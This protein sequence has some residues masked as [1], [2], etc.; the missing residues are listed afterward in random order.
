MCGISGIISDSPRDLK[1]LL[2]TMNASI[3]H[4]GPDANGVISSDQIGLGHVRLSIIDLSTHANQPFVDDEDN[5]ALVFN[6]EIYNFEEL[7]EKYNFSC[8]TSSDTE[9]LFKGLK[10]VGKD[11][12][13]ELNG[14][15]SLAFWNKENDEVLIARDR[16]GIKPIYVYNKDGVIAFCSELKGLQSIENELNGFSISMD[17]V[18]AFMYLGFIPAPLTIYNEI[19]KFEQGAI[20]VIKQGKISYQK[21]WDL[22]DCITEKTHNDERKAKSDLKE[23]VNSSI[24]YRLKSDVPFGTFLSGGIDS[25]LVTAVAQDL[26]EE[27]VK[28]FSI[29]F[30]NPKFNEA[31]F[32]KEVA[33]YLKTDHHEFLVS[34]NEAKVLVEDLIAHYDEP[35]G[36]PSSIPTMM[37]SEMARKHVKMVLSGDGGDEVFHGYGFYNWANR[38]SNPMIKTFR[39]PIGK[40]LSKGNNRVKRASNVF[41]Y[42][43]GKMKSHIFS[44]E[45]YF[46][47]QKE[48]REFLKAPN[49][50][51]EFLDEPIT[52]K[53]ELSPKE[54]QSLYDIKYFLRDDLLN[55]VDIASMKYSLEVRVPLLD[56][57]LIEFG[58]NVHEDLKIKGQDS[59]YI[60]KQVL[61]DYIP[62]KF[63]DR[64]KKGF[65][66]PLQSWLDTDLSYLIDDNLNK[67]TVE[68]IG[69]VHFE[70]VEELLRRYRG[71]E[72]YLF[73]RIWALII[74]HEW[75]KRN[76]NE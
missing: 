75:I 10:T 57:R 70:K 14:M 5:Y 66:I 63:F 46:F 76:K 39:T 9:V 43:K 62:K 47:S 67:S 74:L 71:G 19:Q 24:K 42:P 25:S 27:P 73:T 20:A 13:K 4:R 35:F 2:S 56:H 37:V 61:Y 15:F 64:P 21:F 28:T 45:Q 59:K 72:G 34:E 29:G 6:G 8:K 58:V 33:D 11:F 65:N 38:L 54:E 52:G 7:R 32:A 18:N 30:D 23:L 26:T 50:E 41:L 60:L 17:A 22:E 48:I 12:I 3:N 36:D 1:G 40:L 53:R 68:S 31:N 16:L 55:K 49:H 44:Q 69:I 51:P